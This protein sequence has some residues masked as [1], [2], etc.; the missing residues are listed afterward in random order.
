M[1]KLPEPPKKYREFIER[2]PALGE[3]WERIHDAGQEGPLDD[4]TIR[5]VK[6]G[7]AIGARL[8]GPVH[9][10]VRKG[11]AQGITRE[12]LEQVVALSAGA[13]GLPSA[14]A[15]FTWI[16]DVLNKD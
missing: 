1:S 15:A 3:A 5:L 6:L 12:E 10:S 16:R 8:E 2:Y 14:A 13:I 11:L 9:S 7:I 4:R